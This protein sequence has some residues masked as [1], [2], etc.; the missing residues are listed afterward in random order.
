MMGGNGSATV[1]ADFDTDVFND[2]RLDGKAF[3]AGPVAGKTPDMIASFRSYAGGY[4]A[5]SSHGGDDSKG[6]LTSPLITLDKPYLAFLV[7]GGSLPGKTAVQLLVDGAV[8]MEATGRNDLEMRSVVWDVKTLK[9]RKVQI[10]LLDDAKGSWGIIAADHFML[11]D[12][13][14]PEFPPQGNAD[15]RPGVKMLTHPTMPGVTLPEGMVLDVIADWKNEKTISPTALTV[16]EANNI[17][18]AETHRFRFGVE[19]D[20]DHLYWIT[21]D[22]ASQT[23]DDRRKMYEKWASKMPMEKLTAKSELVRKLADEDGDG[24]YEKSTVFADG[25]NDALDGTGSGVFAY[26]GTTYFACIPKIWS[27][28]DENGDGVADSKGVVEDGFGVRVSISGHDLNGFVLG[29]DGRIYG[30]SGD[31][32]MSLTTKEGRKYHYPGEGVAFRFEPDGTNFEIFHTGLRNPKEIAFDRYGNPFTVDNNCG[33]GDASRVIYLM[34]GGDSGWRMEHQM[35]LSFH[36][37]LGMEERPPIQWSEEYLWQ[38]PGVKQPAFVM[39]AAGYLTSG[40]SGLTYN[41]GTGL[42]ES[43]DNHFHVCDYRGGSTNSGVYSFEMRPKGAGME[44]VESR[45]LVWG[46]GATDVEYSYDGRLFITDFMNGWTSHEKGRV[47]ALSSGGKTWRKEE[48]AEAGVLVRSGFGKLSSQEAAVYLKHPDMRVRLR[49]QIAIARRADGVETFSRTVLSDDRLERIHSLWGLGI[50]ARRGVAEASSEVKTAAIEMIL[51]LLAHEDEETRVQ[52]IRALEASPASSTRIPFPVLLIDSSVRVRAEALIAMARLGE[53]SMISLVADAIRND[54]ANDP[55]LRQAGIY[56]L[57]QLA[58]KGADL[59]SLATDSSS[60]LRIAVVVAMRRTGDARIVE[61][62]NDGSNAVADEAIR[63]ICDLDMKELRP[64]VALL[65]DQ[66]KAREWTPYMMRR[67]LHNSFRLGDV[68]NLERLLAV[69][70][71]EALQQGVR[72]EALRLISVWTEPLTNDQL[73]GHYRPL[74]LRKMEDFRPVLNAALPS[75]LKRDGIVLTAALKYMEQFKLDAA[76]LDDEALFRIASGKELPAPARAKAIDLLA[77]RGSPN[78]QTYL[79]KL[80]E[81]GDD[82]V[83]SSAISHLAEVDSGAAFTVLEKASVESHFLRAQKCWPVLAGL[84]GEQVDAHFVRRLHAL[85]ASAGKSPDAIELLAA[86]ETRKAG[87][88][89]ESLAACRNAI[90]ADKDPLAKWNISLE[91]GNA[92]NGLALFN[93]HPMGQCARCHR[94]SD[95]GHANGGNAGPTLMGIGKRHDRRFLLESIVSPS[96][97][98]S[99]GFGAIAVTFKDQSTLG[100][101]LEGDGPDHLDIAAGDT[102]WRV[103]KSDLTEIP[104]AFSPMPPMEQLLKPEEVRDL[105]A[106]LETLQTE[107][108]QKTAKPEPKPYVLGSSGKGKAK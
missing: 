47:L 5:C 24:K 76:A 107:S 108:K 8:V 72:A 25:F 26:E 78:L 61:F 4:F 7:G 84:L 92:A 53:S 97:S 52:A 69:A 63:A 29:P 54:G 103:K 45:E 75:L 11:T 96:A 32:G 42:S 28:R 68:R 34:E 43:E 15:G 90:A 12:D 50:I 101:L 46:I 51:P 16:D 87:V 18:I 14:A 13:A 2:W 77:E 82:E 60:A 49:A 56:A 100:G 55:W 62:I 67:L 20:Q 58:A 35:L 66:P 99:P 27:L 6:S 80:A 21:D 94:A 64:A 73:T 91:G 36:R 88:V 22:T 83:F 106:W 33:L 59:G 1:L 57:E 17:F 38:M 81:D 74:P 85:A 95:E 65:L 93:S 9:G 40:P 37:Q 3:G 102:I 48:G 44:M 105:V 98:I 71:N 104:T 19:D 79:S 30:T 41:P 39:P 89:K 23:T 10:R 86:A 70:C 31:R